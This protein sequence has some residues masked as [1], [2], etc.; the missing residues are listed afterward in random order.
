MNI[1]EGL[2]YTDEHEWISVEGKIGRVGIS[3]YA[4]H[5]LGDIV[6]VEL[7]EIEAGVAE[8]EAIGVIESVK[9]V[10]SLFSPASGTI[11]EVNEE[12]ETAPELLNQDCYASWIAL[13]ELTGGSE[14]EKLMDAKAYA[15]FC[16]TLD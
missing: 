3:D 4:Q 7:P 12:L 11:L 2:L 8:G 9:A 16:A 10:A 13:I 14:L 6:Y 15:E 1:K 5:Q